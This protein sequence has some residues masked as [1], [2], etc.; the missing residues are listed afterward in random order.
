MHVLLC[1]I[2]VHKKKQVAKKKNL[3]VML[4]C[5]LTSTV[6]HHVQDNKAVYVVAEPN[7]RYKKWSGFSN[8]AQIKKLGLYC[9]ATEIWTKEFSKFV[10]GVLFSSKSN[11]CP[12]VHSLATS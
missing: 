4:K 11:Y 6:C 3:K 9:P 5:Q 1:I 7:S 12:V 10:R 8:C 2:F